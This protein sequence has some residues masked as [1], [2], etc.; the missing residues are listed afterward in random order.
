LSDLTRIG[1][2]VIGRNEGA[3]LGESLAALRARS[4]PFVYVDSG[5]TDG[6]VGLAR[7]AGAEVVELEADSPFTAARARNAGLARLAELHPEIQNVQFVD[8]DCVLET[9]WISEAAAFLDS[10]NDAAIVTGCLTERHR[11]ASVYNA[12]CALEWER[13]V[14]E[15][16]ACGG[17]FMARVAAVK[18]VGGFRDDLKA[19]EEGELC[20]RLRQRGWKIWSLDTPMAAHDAAM[21]KFSQWWTRARRGGYAY[22]E[23]A[24]MHG[25]SPQRHCVRDCRRIWLWGLVVPLLAIVPA[26]WTRGGSL[27]ILLGYPLLAVRI[28]MGGRNRG[29][30]A[31]DA[32]RYTIFTVLAKFPG[33]LGMLEYHLR[34]KRDVSQR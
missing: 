22:A 34:P 25:D 11:D 26:W 30:N 15:I 23:G 5:S 31:S 3:R 32:R 12:L 16:P 8:G 20:L 27:L 18:E 10:R 7:A 4:V 6:S 33:L 29:W 9:S 2:V 24:A 17:I 13:P 21:T 14:G 1:A 28:Y 19:G